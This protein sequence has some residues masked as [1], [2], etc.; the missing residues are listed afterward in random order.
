[1]DARAMIRDLTD[2]QARAVF[3][4]GLLIEAAKGDEEAVRRVRPELKR[5]LRKDNLM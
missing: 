2:G 4:I 1:M 5:A 3:W